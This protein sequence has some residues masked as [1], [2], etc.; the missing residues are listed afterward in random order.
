MPS[1]TSRKARRE[2]ETGVSLCHYWIEDS[3]YFH[4][5]QTAMKTTCHRGRLLCSVSLDRD[6]GAEAYSF[7]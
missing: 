3:A 7:H 2:T 6:A 1:L 4:V 5:V